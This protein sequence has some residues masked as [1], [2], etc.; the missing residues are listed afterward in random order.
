M[1]G[2]EHVGILNMFFFGRSRKVKNGILKFSGHLIK[3][4]AK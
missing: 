3:D 1:H 4:Y 2:N